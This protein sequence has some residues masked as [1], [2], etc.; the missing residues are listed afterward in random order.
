MKKTLLAYST[1]LILLCAFAG[2]IIFYVYTRGSPQLETTR[3]PSQTTLRGIS[4]TIEEDQDYWVIQRSSDGG[5]LGEYKMCYIQPE[6]SGTKYYLVHNDGE[7]YQTIVLLR[8]GWD[9]GVR[10]NATGYVSSG[11]Y[12]VS[13]IK[14]LDHPH[15]YIV[16][17]VIKL[18]NLSKL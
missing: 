5:Y 18:V 2:I 4:G 8:F 6:N 7:F 12:E 14:V 15:T 1:V 10:F 17:T 16:I 3:Q 11:W 13:Q 9:S